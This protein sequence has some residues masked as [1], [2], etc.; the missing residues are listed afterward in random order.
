MITL[1][2]YKILCNEQH[3]FRQH[4]SCETQLVATIN[5]LAV[6]LNKGTQVDVILLDLAKAFDTVPHNRLVH[7]LST[8]GI[9]G[10]LLQ[11]IKSFLVNRSQQVT[12]NGQ[13]SSTTQVISGVPQGSVLGP[14]LFICYTYE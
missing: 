5:D 11:W 6:A 8:Y 9:N 10:K 2:D 14:L 7:K 12:V 4:R 13:L 3:G 1:I